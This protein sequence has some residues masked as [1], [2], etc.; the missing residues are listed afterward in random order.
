MSVLVTF[1]VAGNPKGAGR[2]R[3]RIITPKSGAAF[4]HNYMPAE[5]RNW[6]ATLR[7]AGQNAMGDRAP[8]DCALAVVLI[9]TLIVPQS[10]SR[11]KREAALTG[12][13]R[14][15]VK[16][17]WDNIAKMTDGLNGIV[18]VDAKPIVDG[19]VVKWYGLKPEVEFRVGTCVSG[20]LGL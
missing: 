6:Q 11:K 14:P 5:T 12:D 16:P 15:T 9:C 1:T 3:H 13:L 2:Q 7:I 20:G 10:W 17:D 4:V 8:Y 18:W 19:R